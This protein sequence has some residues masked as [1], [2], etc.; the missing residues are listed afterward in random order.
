M[1][2]LKK[3]EAENAIALMNGQWLGSRY[4]LHGYGEEEADIQVYR[5]CA[6]L[7]KRKGHYSPKKSFMSFL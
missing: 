2:F 5:Y 4:A 1:S 6:Y 3:V 7:R